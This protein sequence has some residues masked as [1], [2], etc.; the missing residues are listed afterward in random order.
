MRRNRKLFYLNLFIALSILFSVIYAVAVGSTYR[1]HAITYGSKVELVDAEMDC[2]TDDIVT[3][4]G[5]GIE[6][7]ELYF[8]L[9]SVG[10]GNVNATLSARVRF[11]D[12]T[13]S[14]YT[15][16]SDLHVTASGM[17]VDRTNGYNYQGYR[18]TIYVSLLVMLA[19]VVVML[20]MCIDYYR[21]GDFCYTMVAFGGISIFMLVVLLFCIYKLLNNVV[22]SFGVFIG[23]IADIGIEVLL[24]LTPFMLVLSVALS[25]SNIWLMRHEGFRPVNA[26]GIVFGVLWLLVTV[27]TIGN[28]M[29]P[30]LWTIPGYEMLYRFLVYIASYLECMFLSTMICAYLST[31]RVPSYDKD[32]IIILGCAIRR[33]GSLTPLLRA[34]ADSAVA[35]EKAQFDA[36]GKHAV[37]VPSGG[38]GADEVISEGEA[39]QRYL[40]EIGVSPK[41]ILPETEST[42][43]NENMRFSKQV[44]EQHT[45]DIGAQ[46]VA[47]STTNYHVFRG[48]ILS[49]KNGFSAQGISAR[50]KPYFYLN[51]F[52]REFIGLLYDQRYRHIAYLLV[53]LQFFVLLRFA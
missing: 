3:M 42:S 25:I 46:K 11:A 27:L 6:D 17:I 48:Y 20:W 2:D 4:T 32:Y 30:F 44:I 34:R 19:V 8:D 1:V 28:G 14:S 15:T 10:V 53:T 9:H 7:G 37:F 47:F 52:L 18:M 24:A 13:E 50:T 49:R 40:T 41:R 31:R 22:N 21:R 26:L 23:L 5:A 36:T 51:A 29:M 16:T 33:D 39:I 45:G 12:G 35:F 43:T 38:K